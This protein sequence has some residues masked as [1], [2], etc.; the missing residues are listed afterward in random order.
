MTIDEAREA[1]RQR[2]PIIYNESEYA[3]ISGI[4]FKFDGRGN[5]TPLLE[6]YDK[7]GHSYTYARPRFVTLKGDLK[8]GG[9][10]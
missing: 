6:L 10:E 9:D 3:C 1:A 2:L 4:C 7:T 5:T 8:N